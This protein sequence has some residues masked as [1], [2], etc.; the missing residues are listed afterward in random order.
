[1]GRI[2]VQIYLTVT[3]TKKGHTLKLFEYKICLARQSLRLRR[4]ERLRTVFP[5]STY[6]KL[7]TYS[8]S[9]LRVLK[10]LDLLLVIK[11]IHKGSFKQP[12]L[13][14]WLILPYNKSFIT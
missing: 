12:L 1:M 9:V 14:S 6:S 11:K 4:H 7:T 8:I 5:P 13:Q 2:H 3:C 10:V